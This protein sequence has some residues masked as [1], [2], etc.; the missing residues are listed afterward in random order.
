MV[1]EVP[2]LDTFDPNY[3]GRLGPLIT[4]HLEPSLEGFR[5]Y[6]FHILFS[7]RGLPVKRQTSDNGYVTVPLGWC[8]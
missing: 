4:Q 7:I 5:I 3:N 8:L 2:V 6:N 1:S